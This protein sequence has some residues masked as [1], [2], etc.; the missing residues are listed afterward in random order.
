MWDSFLN[1]HVY[2]TPLQNAHSA[3]LTGSKVMPMLL[4][5]RSYFEQQGS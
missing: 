4:L 5:R 3:F 2:M 1:F